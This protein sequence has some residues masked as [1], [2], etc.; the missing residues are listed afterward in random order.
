MSLND[1]MLNE[2]LDEW[3]AYF[4]KLKKEQEKSISKSNEKNTKKPA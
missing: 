4:E 3:V 1:R 2:R